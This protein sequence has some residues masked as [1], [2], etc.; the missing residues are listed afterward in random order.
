M[1]WKSILTCFA[2]V[3]MNLITNSHTNAGWQENKKHWPRLICESSDIAII[4]AHH[5]AAQKGIEPY[6][7]LW[8]RIQKTAYLKPKFNVKDWGQQNVNGGIIKARAFLYALTG[9]KN[10]APWVRDGLLNMYPG[11]EI[12]KYGVTTLTLKITS[13]KNLKSSVIQSIHM[14]QSLTQHCQAYDMLKGASYEFGS[15]EADIKKNIATLAERI[16]DISNW[17]SSGAKAAELIQEDVEE[18]NN[19]Q[20]KMMSALG[21]AAICLN[22]HPSAEKWMNRAMTKF[23]QVFTAQ[24]TPKGGYGEGPFYFLYA[25]LNFMPF[26]HAYNLFMDGQGGTFDGYKVPNFLSDE[27]VAKA[28]DWHLKI[29]MPNGD[30]PGYDDGYYAAFMSGLLVSDPNMSGHATDHYPSAN[31]DVYA[32]DWLNTEP[33]TGGYDNRYLS[34]FANLDLTVDLFCIFDADAKPGEPSGSPTQF[35]PDAGNTV[36]RSDW[37]KDAVYML[38]LGEKGNMRLMGG[39]HEHSDAGSFV[40]FAHGELLALDAGY[41]GFPQH[42]KVNQA[43]NHSVILVD[44]QGP[45]TDAE[46]GEFLDTSVLDFASVK[47]AYSGANVV[48]NVVFI[49]NQYFILIDQLESMS[50]HDYT[51]LLHGNAGTGLANSSFS[52][53]QQGGIWKRPKASLEAYVISDRGVPIYEAG[54]DYHSFTFVSGNNPLPKHAVLKM[55]QTANQLRYLSVL[56]PLPQGANSPTISEIETKGG[57]CLKVERQNSSPLFCAV[58][59][60]LSAMSIGTNLPNIKEITTDGEFALLEFSTQSELPTLLFAKNMAKLSYMNK[61]ILSAK[62]KCN[63]IMVF[64]EKQKVFHGEVQGYDNNYLVLKFAAQNAKVIGAKSFTFQP[65]TQTLQIDF[66]KPKPFRIEI[67]K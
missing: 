24:T 18:Q 59:G 64:N 57:V 54:E 58:R 47:M 7:T 50:P 4:R 49:D 6:K 9:E 37:G 15:T 48:R 1:K 35:F 31:L 53:T 43:K 16:Y 65:G 28:F 13:Y 34:A 12:P 11:E 38:V 51:W 26:F 3:L 30:R 56:T 66:E 32:W 22:D 46:L 25:G 52:K 5:E 41:P 27:R 55:R 40:I 17:I 60:D 67:S 10:H 39:V 23:W 20:L 36:F 21:L 63:I 61:D 29:R 8:E 45:D 62:H 2:F 42:D 33:M 19:F 44:G 14:A